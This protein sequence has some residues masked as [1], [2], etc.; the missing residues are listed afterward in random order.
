MFKETERELCYTRLSLI[1]VGLV[2]TELLHTFYEVQYKIETTLWNKY[3]F[4][5]M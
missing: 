5:N 2:K 4:K 3:V 1:R